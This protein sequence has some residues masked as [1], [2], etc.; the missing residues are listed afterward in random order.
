IAPVSPSSPDGLDDAWQT[1]Y[2]G[3]P[4]NVLAGPNA[5]PDGDGAS[6]WLEF[7]SGTNPNSAASRPQITA[8]FPDTNSIEVA[9]LS[10]T[11]HL[12][13]VDRSGNLSVWNV[14]SNGVT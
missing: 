10:A 9:W 8:T 5:D 3:S 4:T 2:S 11:N 1:L 13:R 6:N 7:H 14:V 12:F